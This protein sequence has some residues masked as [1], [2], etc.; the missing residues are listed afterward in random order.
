MFKLRILMLAVI[1]STF[2]FLNSACVS[3]IE[4]IIEAL[5]SDEN[6]NVNQNINNASGN[7]GSGGGPTPLPDPNG[8]DQPTLNQCPSGQ[9]GT[10]PNCV[11]VTDSGGNGGGD[12]SSTLPLQS[13]DFNLRFDN[14]VGGIK[15]SI[16]SQDNGMI[17]HYL[18]T[19]TSEPITDRSSVA[20]QL[21]NDLNTNYSTHLRAKRP[22]IDGENLFWELRNKNSSTYAILTDLYANGTYI[23]DFEAGG[24][25][26]TGIPS[27]TYI[28]NGDAYLAPRRG[29]IYLDRGEFNMNVNFDNSLGNISLVSN[30][31]PDQLELELTGS[32]RINSSNGIYYSDS[33]HLELIDKHYGLNLDDD[34]TIYGA[35]HDQ[36]ATGVSGIFFDTDR[37]I[38]GG[39]FAGAR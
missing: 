25:K 10:P 15:R 21:R 31:R 32:F 28:Y 35:F 27:G 38:Y 9:T 24:I 22:T 23:T 33:L 16:S 37:K 4:R 39:A 3:T 7:G 14:E 34:A 26:A 5:E 11:L 17:I 30:S 6:N 8:D 12:G 13:R 2:A 36:G 29:G 18:N 19:I 1:L 20:F